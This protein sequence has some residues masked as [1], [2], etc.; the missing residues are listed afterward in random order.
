M[1]NH[2][3][4]YTNSTGK[5]PLADSTSPSWRRRSSISDVLW[6]RRPLSIQWLF[7]L[8][9]EALA[10]SGLKGWN[11]QRAMQR[12]G[13]SVPPSRGESKSSADLDV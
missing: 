10:F 1:A 9:A 6:A 4:A 12:L 7:S 5:N 11:L 13:G 2:V 3:I 8:E